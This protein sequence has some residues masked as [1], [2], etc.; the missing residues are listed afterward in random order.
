M[1]NLV[2]S[3]EE[4]T[5]DGEDLMKLTRL[6]LWSLKNLFQ[7]CW[8]EVFFNELFKLFNIASPWIQEYRHSNISLPNVKYFHCQFNSKC[9]ESPC[10]YSKALWSKDKTVQ[11]MSK[12]TYHTIPQKRPWWNSSIPSIS[13]VSS[14]HPLYQL[15]RIKQTKIHKAPSLLILGPRWPSRLLLHGFQRRLLLI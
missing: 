2:F 5:N 15:T 1:S 4:V 8:Q 10:P 7:S 3:L 9:S 14:R 6:A 11:Y 13:L 12:L